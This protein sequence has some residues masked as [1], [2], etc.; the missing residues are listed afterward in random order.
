MYGKDYKTTFFDGYLG[1]IKIQEVREPQIWKFNGED[2]VVCD[3]GVTWLSILPND[4]WY[5][6]TAMFSEK[7]EILVWYIDMI[8]GQG[9]DKDEVPYID[10][11]YLDLVV[12]PDGTIIEDD[13]D[14]LEYALVTKD[15]TEEQYHLA[16]ETSDKLKKKISY[17]ILDFVKYT[18][19][20][21]ELVNE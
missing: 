6:I 17:N 15:I 20:C 11:L 19:Q 9:I 8:A 4:D 1:F 5:C 2:I 10:D 12:Y 7:E 16:I 14:E 13:M 3:K 21:Y 18:K